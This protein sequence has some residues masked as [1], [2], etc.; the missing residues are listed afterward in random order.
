[1]FL[2]CISFADDICSKYKFDTD[3]NMKDTTVYEAKIKSSKDNLVDKMGYIESSLS[4]SL[5]ELFVNIPVKNGYCVS[6]RS[7]DIEINTPEFNIIIDR[8]LNPKTCAYNIVLSHETDHMN[9][10]KNIIKNNI[11]DIKKSVKNAT[12]TIKPVFISD[13]N[14]IE[15]AKSD[16]LKQIESYSD[17]KKIKDKI[18]SEIIEKNNEIDIRGDSYDMWKC[19]DFYKE[20]KNNTN[21]TID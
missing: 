2:P 5:K 3:V 4:Y 12:N 16:V 8:R 1:M 9:V 14:N 17:V 15:T 10:Y 13:L 7:V 20:M 21:I 19:E 6:L 11:E 18:T